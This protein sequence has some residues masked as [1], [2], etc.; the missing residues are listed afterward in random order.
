M[1]PPWGEKLIFEPLC[2]NST[3]MAALCARLPVII[4]RKA[5]L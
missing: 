2:K 1:S 4:K 5:A 3:G